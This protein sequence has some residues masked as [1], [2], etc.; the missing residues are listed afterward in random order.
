MPLRLNSLGKRVA[1]SPSGADDSMRSADGATTLEAGA[2]ALSILGVWSVYWLAFYPAVVGWDPLAQL[3][4]IESEKYTDWHP[5]LHTLLLALFYKV[6]E[7]VA[8]LAFC[9]MLAAA[10]LYFFAY[11]QL[12]ALGAPRWSLLAMAAWLTLSPAFGYELIAIWKDTPFALGTLALVCLLLR[13]TK[14]GPAGWLCSP[15][16]ASALNPPER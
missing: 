2:V 13:L 4:Q 12:S 5:A 3:A 16:L 6:F 15:S 8:A 14:G 1:A 9:Q 7:S 11:C 10:A